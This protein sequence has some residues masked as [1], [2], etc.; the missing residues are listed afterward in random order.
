MPVTQMLCCCPSARPFKPS[1]LLLSSPVVVVAPLISA[2]EAWQLLAILKH[3]QV[4][5]LSWTKTGFP[6]L[7]VIDD[8]YVGLQRH[9][10]QEPTYKTGPP[11]SVD[12]C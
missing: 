10:E 5:M 8:Y 9:D 12:Q 3:G 2:E 7:E 4:Q 11:V 6:W 1:K